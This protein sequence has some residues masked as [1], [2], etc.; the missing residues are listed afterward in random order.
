M[1]VLIFVIDIELILV[2]THNGVTRDSN[3]NIQI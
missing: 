1:F 3:K 2:I